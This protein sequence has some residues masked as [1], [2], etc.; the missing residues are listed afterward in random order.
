MKSFSPER[1][2]V[3]IFNN[4]Y[5]VYKFIQNWIILFFTYKCHWNISLYY[6][7][8]KYYHI[9]IIHKNIFLL[10]IY[11]ERN[12]Y[13]DISKIA[14]RYID[15]IKNTSIIIN[16]YLC[17]GKF[18]VFDLSKPKDDSLAIWLRFNILLNLQKEI[19]VK[20]KYREK[21]ILVNL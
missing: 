18:I 3:I 21:S 13:Q 10:V 17:K 8:Q 6:I 9:L 7:I 11:N 2:I 15:N 12:S 20:Q 14:G 16:N 1:S 5:V 4:I 19:K